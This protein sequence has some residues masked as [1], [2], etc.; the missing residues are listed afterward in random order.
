MRQEWRK[1][2]LRQRRV[3]QAKFDRYVVEAAWSEAAIEVPQ[4]GNDDSRNRRFD[5]RSGLVQHK[6]IKPGFSRDIDAGID[7]FAG[8]VERPELR[9]RNDRR[10][11]AAVRQQE[12]VVAQLQRRNVVEAG[13]F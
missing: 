12:R 7:L 10:R 1:F 13:L 5:V 4:T 6:E 2:A 11:S 9:T 3:A 8:V